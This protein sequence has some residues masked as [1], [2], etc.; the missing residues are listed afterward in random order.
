LNEPDGK[1]DPLAVLRP[2]R[3]VDGLA[4][5]G[6]IATAVAGSI[7]IA[8]SRALEIPVHFGV[9]GVAMLGTSVVYNVDRLRDL[10]RDRKNA[11]LR[12]EFIE[13]HRPFLVG[14]VALSAVASLG[15][16]W[17]LGLAALLLCAGVLVTGLMHR[18]LKVLR[19]I[20]CLYVAAAW[21]AVVVG[22]PLLGAE[23]LESG[24]R[25]GPSVGWTV[26]IV[27]CGF[28]ANLLASN[29]EPE[30]SAPAGAKARRVFSGVLALA[31]AASVFGI[32]FA[33]LGPEQFQALG[34]IPAAEMA[35]LAS[36]Q[37]GE[38]FRLIAL[39]GALVGGAL[40]AIVWMP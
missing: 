38:R 37:S 40:A 21:T 5:A 27:G 18:R 14:L 4:Y 26:A 20:K 3:W 7:T 12:S 29:I 8:V 30:I 34:F 23:S 9:V 2:S 25:S 22:L 24:S 16:A 13:R 32:V 35:A 31:A 17:G 11:P 1:T 39:D 28:L 36:Y 10:S 15:L 19:S 6:I 33:Y